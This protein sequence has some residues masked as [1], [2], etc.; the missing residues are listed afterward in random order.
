VVRVCRSASVPE[1][2]REPTEMAMEMREIAVLA[3]TDP[4]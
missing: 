1:T 4:R 3:S 2:I